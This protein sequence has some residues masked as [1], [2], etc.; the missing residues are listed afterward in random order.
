ME[1]D[2]ESHRV[3]SPSHSGTSGGGDGAGV[4]TLL[5]SLASVIQPPGD[6][7]PPVPVSKFPWHFFV[8]GQKSQLANVSVSA[9]HCSHVLSI[10]GQIL[11]YCVWCRWRFVCTLV[12]SPSHSSCA[13]ATAAKNNTV[14][15]N[16]F[17]FSLLFSAQKKNL[18]KIWSFVLN[19]QKMCDPKK[20]LFA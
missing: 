15:R 8:P 4:N 13:V 17:L 12:V 18:E 7:H 11:R 6:V 14:E 20:H 16:I 5:Q 3:V 9:M 19:K 2:E 1:E 10:F